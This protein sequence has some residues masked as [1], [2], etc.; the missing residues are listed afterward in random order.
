MTSIFV[1]KGYCLPPNIVATLSGLGIMQTEQKHQADF[2]VQRVKQLPL[3]VELGRN[4]KL[5]SLWIGGPLSEEERLGLFFS[6]DEILDYLSAQ[7]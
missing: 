6:W 1:G 3:P 2:I 7:V 4:Q 5:I